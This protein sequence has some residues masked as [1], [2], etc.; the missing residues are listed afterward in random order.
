M[1]RR[2]EA[3]PDVSGVTISA[4]VPG[5]ELSAGVEIEGLD[6]ASGQSSSI[7]AAVNRVDTGFFEVF[8][9]PSAGR[10]VVRGRRPPVRASRDREPDLRT[11]FRG[12]GDP[13][14]H[15]VRYVGSTAGPARD[16]ESLYE[17]VLPTRQLGGR[18]LPGAVPAAA[19]LMMVAGVV[20]AVGPARRA[21]RIEPV[22]AVRDG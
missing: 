2:L 11:T 13:E 15:R 20:A 12:A 7:N 6:P 5:G 19:A 4:A 22:E 17:I 14:G 18:S 16:P 1:V 10:P 8:D 9:A 3:E 21:L